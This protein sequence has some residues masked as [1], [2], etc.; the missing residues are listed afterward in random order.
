MS[1]KDAEKATQEAKRDLT[2][3][4]ERSLPHQDA[5]GK[6]LS[7]LAYSQRKRAADQDEADERSGATR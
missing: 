7:A 3:H 2:S 5:I 4:P 1:K 6:Y